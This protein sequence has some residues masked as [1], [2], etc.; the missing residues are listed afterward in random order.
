LFVPVKLIRE[1]DNRFNQIPNSKRCGHVAR[2]LIEGFCG[3]LE[4]DESFY[5]SIESLPTLFFLDKSR[6]T[7]TAQLSGN[8]NRSFTWKF[9]RE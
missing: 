7:A 8:Q 6:K 4:R 2:S 5:A 3:V 1:F 9:S